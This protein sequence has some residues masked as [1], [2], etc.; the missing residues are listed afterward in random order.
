MFALSSGHE[1]WDANVS[2]LHPPTGGCSFGINC[3]AAL[4]KVPELI[5]NPVCIPRPTRAQPAL[6][7]ACPHWTARL[8]SLA[9]PLAV[10]TK[11]LVESRSRGVFQFRHTPGSPHTAC[12][13]KTCLTPLWGA[14]APHFAPTVRTRPALDRPSALFDNHRIPSLAHPLCT[15][16]VHCTL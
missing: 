8:S 7:K 2:N 15:P 3:K 11:G 14:L 12:H 4:R 16:L 6:A 5:C 9:G 10:Q 13:P 1:R